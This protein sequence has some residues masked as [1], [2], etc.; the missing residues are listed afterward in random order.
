MAM[1]GTYVQIIYIKVTNCICF[2]RNKRNNLLY[3]LWGPHLHSCTHTP[4]LFFKFKSN[5]IC[6]LMILVRSLPLRCTWK[7]KTPFFG[8]LSSFLTTFTVH[9]RLIKWCTLRLKNRQSIGYAWALPVLKDDGI[10]KSF[11]LSI[12]H[13]FPRLYPFYVLDWMSQLWGIEQTEPYR[14]RFYGAKLLIFNR[15]SNIL[16]CKNAHFF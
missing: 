5:L 10:Q 7:Q 8:F 12:P 6:V 2:S 11:L 16:T 9:E 4:L 14:C 3:E 1:S 13:F 15:I